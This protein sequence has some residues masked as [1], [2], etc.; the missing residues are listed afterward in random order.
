[1][2]KLT[3]V[4][5][6]PV[7]AA[8]L[9]FYVLSAHAIPCIPR[10]PGQGLEGSVACLNGAPRDNTLGSGDDKAFDLNAGNYFGFND[11]RFL[12]LQGPSSVETVID[13]GLSLVFINPAMGSWSI[14]E[15]TW[16]DNDN[17]VAILKADVTGE[18]MI[19]WSSYL[20][21]DGA[22]IGDWLSVRPLSSFSIFGRGSVPIPEP[23]TWSTVA[24]GLVAMVWVGNIR[25]K[26][27]FPTV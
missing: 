16:Q 14:F 19:Y 26:R 10:I 7:W 17:I 18:E 27:M 23:D 24:M 6:L 12:Q 15:S 8:F 20:L 5:G 25:R 22:T 4:I 2:D 21:N 3:G 9:C 13:V 1:M 11:W